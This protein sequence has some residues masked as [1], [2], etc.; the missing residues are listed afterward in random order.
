[1][2]LYRCEEWQGSSGYWYCEHTSTFPHNVQKW[3]VPARILGVSPADF[4]QLLIEKFKPDHIWHNEDCSFVGWGWKSQSQM[5][6]YKNWINAE[7]RKKNFQ[8]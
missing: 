3:V 6:V 1:M 8:I 5:R 4:I 2:A 7:A